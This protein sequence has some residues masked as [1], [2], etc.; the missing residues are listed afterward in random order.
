MRHAGARRLR[1]LRRRRR[2]TAR[3][4]RV[5][6]RARNPCTFLRRLLLGWYVLFIWKPSGWFAWSPI[7]G[8]HSRACTGE[9]VSD[10]L[11]WA[12]TRPHATLKN[13]LARRPGQ[14]SRCLGMGQSDPRSVPLIMLERASNSGAR[15]RLGPRRPRARRRSS[16]HRLPT[17]RRTLILY[18]LYFRI[19]LLF[20]YSSSTGRVLRCGPPGPMLYCPRFPALR[21]SPPTM[22]IVLPRCIFPWFNGF[23]GFPQ[24]WMAV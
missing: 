1:P 14:A 16:G 18:S 4:A 3:P 11:G 12:A 9:C 7:E 20:F 19:Y 24:L 5:R 22:V 23:W 15:S 13:T 17:R 2:S 10:C 8:S 21:S 6:L